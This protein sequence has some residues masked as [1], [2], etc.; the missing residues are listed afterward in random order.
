MR[1]SDEYLGTCGIEYS[2][3]VIIEVK[4]RGYG[5]VVPLLN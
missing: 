2:A 5:K 3:C 1:I 4:N